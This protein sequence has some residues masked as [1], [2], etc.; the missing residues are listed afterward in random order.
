M[1]AAPPIAR[2]VTPAML[3]A[4]GAASGIS[5]IFV[6]L[7]LDLAAER[8]QNAHDSWAC[9]SAIDHELVTLTPEVGRGLP[10][11]SPSR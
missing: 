3:T 9:G 5:Q 7:G 8:R 1:Y 2:Q 11:D 6:V 4:S 10:K